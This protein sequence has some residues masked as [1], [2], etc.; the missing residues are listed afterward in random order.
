MILML[1]FFLL[2]TLIL[3]SSLLAAASFRPTSQGR[4][5]S[6]HFSEISVRLRKGIRAGFVLL[7]PMEK[8]WKKL[9]S[10][11]PLRLSLPR[12]QPPLYSFSL[13]FCCLFPIFLFS[14]FPSSAAILCYIIYGLNYT[15]KNSFSEREKLCVY[16]YLSGKKGINYLHKNNFNNKSPSLRRVCQQTM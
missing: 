16:V 14:F 7:I 12:H 15:L 11:P 9:V 1:K 8:E 2:I 13:T 4:R 10:S 3:G 6:P 5:K